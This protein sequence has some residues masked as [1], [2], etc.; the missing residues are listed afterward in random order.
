MW[1]AVKLIKTC[2]SLW[3]FIEAKQNETLAD[4][5]LSTVVTFFFFENLT[6]LVQNACECTYPRIE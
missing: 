6:T 2:I 3:C 5:K 4:C 1:H